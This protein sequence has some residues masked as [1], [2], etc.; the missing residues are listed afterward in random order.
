MNLTSLLIGVI[1]NYDAVMRFVKEG[2]EET[3]GLFSSKT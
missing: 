3:T 2:T 1:K